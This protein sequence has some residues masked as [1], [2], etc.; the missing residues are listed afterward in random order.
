[1]EKLAEFSEL[2]YSQISKIERGLTNTTIR[3]L[4]KI[5]KALGVPVKDLFDFE[6]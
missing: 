3:T 1:M 4:N 2:D 5:S 6:L